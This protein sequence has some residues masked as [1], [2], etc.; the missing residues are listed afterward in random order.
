MYKN[1]SI[2]IK[3]TRNNK[4]KIE[5]DEKNYFF[6]PKNYLINEDRIIYSL[7]EMVIPNKSKTD[8]LL[9]FDTVTNDTITNEKN[10]YHIININ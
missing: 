7:D 6:N 1:D 9:I 10:K 2:F 8:N 4:L 5:L 3:T